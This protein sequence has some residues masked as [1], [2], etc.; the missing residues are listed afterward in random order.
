MKKIKY[1][2]VCLVLTLTLITFAGCNKNENPT[3]EVKITNISLNKDSVTTSNTGSINVN[4]LKIDVFYSDNTKE[5]VVVTSDMITK[6]LEN[7][8]KEGTHTIEISYKGKTIEVTI[9]ISLPI[10]VTKVSLNEDS[11]LSCV[12]VTFP[13]DNLQLDVLYSDGKVKVVDVTEEMIVEGIENLSIEGTHIIKIKYDTQTIEVTI[14]LTKPIIVTSI[15]VNKISQLTFEQGLFDSSNIFIVA[16]YSDGSSFTYTVKDSMLSDIE[17]LSEVGTHELTITY[18]GCTTEVTIVITKPFDYS[19]YDLVKNVNGDGYEIASYNGDETEIYLPSTYQG[20]PIVGINERAFYGNTT[21]KKIVISESIKYIKN[22]AFYQVPT[23]SS[24]SIPLT[25]ETIEAYAFGTV[26][27]DKKV[28]YYEGNT[29]PSAWASNWYDEQHAYIHFNIAPSEIIRSGDYEYYIKNN[30]LVLGDYFGNETSLTV[31]EKI[32]QIDVTIIGGACFKGNATVQSL[33]IPNTVIEIQKYGISECTNL[34]QLT[35]SNT[36]VD[37]GPYALR[38]CEE[39]KKIIL[40]ASLRTI[41]ANAFNMCSGLEE[42]II[43]DGVVSIGAYAFAWCT[44]ATKIYL[45]NTLVEVKGGACYACSKATIYTSY[46]SIPSTWESGWNM[47]GRPIVYD[48]K[49]A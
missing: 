43:P 26:Q 11:I 40:P 30:Q 12:D 33:V 20:L 41:G 1:L 45:P 42:I 25:V 44:S 2:I 16:H 14:Q 4:D 9:T 6:G 37:L 32:D 23:L 38:G 31:P 3:E 28:I 7:L 29:I 10:T 27:N 34:T 17:K 18:E 36:L 5:P 35:L 46:S 21:L 47:S 48:Y 24:I 19:A 8:N 49:L 13:L 22:G 15:E 39:I